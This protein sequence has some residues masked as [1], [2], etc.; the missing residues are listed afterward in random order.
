MQTI[1]LPLTPDLLEAARAK[2]LKEDGISIVGDSGEIK[3]HGCDLTFVY[4]GDNLVIT[5]VQKPHLVSA[6]F[7]ESKIRGW[8]EPT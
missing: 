5:V 8:F 2:V 3:A 6:G 4:D 7:I 1:S